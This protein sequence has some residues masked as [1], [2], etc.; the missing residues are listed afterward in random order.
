MTVSVVI[1]SYNGAKTIADTIAS[2]L[3]QDV[4][5]LEV[6]VSDDGSSDGTLKAVRR[7]G[8]ERIR[9]LDDTSRVGPAANWNRAL[10][11]ATQPYVKLLSQDD[12]LYHGNLAAS[13]AALDEHPT[14]ALSAVRRD[15]IGAD[16][17]V[18]LRS[19]GLGGM[20]GPIAADDALKR[21]VRSGGNL[22]GEGACV[23]MRRA[24]VRG[25][26]GFDGSLP[27]VIDIDL[28]LR[29]LGGRSLIAIPETLA[30]FRVHGESWSKEL[31][32]AQGRQFSE[33]IDRLASEHGGTLTA[34]DVRRGKVMAQAN[35]VGRAMFYRRYRKHI[36]DRRV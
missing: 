34:A 30:A 21:V 15:V 3:A 5:G 16:G 20:E 2:V 8:D 10:D 28:W 27:Y 31:S 33:F 36:I 17:T 4:A 24:F 35:G 1:P 13:V 12:L 19:R 7:I 18:L 22:I 11:A 23:V 9:I 25:S 26:G 32:R 6:V 14:S 29:L